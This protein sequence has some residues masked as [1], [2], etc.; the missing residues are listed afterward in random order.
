MCFEFCAQGV[1]V[2]VCM[3]TSLPAG[4]GVVYS[5]KEILYPSGGRVC[6]TALN[7]LGY[8]VN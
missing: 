7:Y 2:A 4:S 6:A 5:F 3:F 1:V 8:C